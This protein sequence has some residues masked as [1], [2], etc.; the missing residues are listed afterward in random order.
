M[1][2]FTASPTKARSAFTLIEL[3][4][5]IAIIAILAAILFPV[6]ARARENARR[7]SCQSNLKQIGLGVMQYTQDYDERFPQTVQ[8]VSQG[9]GW[10]Q[11]I[12]PYIKSYQL[13]QCPSEPTTGAVWNGGSQAYYPGWV[14]PSGPTSNDQT[15]Y[16]YS[17]F[18]GATHGGGVGGYGNGA[19]ITQVNNP[20]VSI[21]SGD[22]GI[23]ADNNGLQGFA[24][25]PRFIAA[26]EQ[27]DLCSGILG[28]ASVTSGNCSN[29]AALDRTGAAIRHLEG[30]N[31]LFAD[32][33]VKF[34]KPSQLYGALTP[35]STSGGSPTFRLYDY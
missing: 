4:V 35:Y 1:K 27:G 13:F 12:N 33:H 26:G 31:Y 20:S 8:N 6:F 2:N 9:L 15:D 34:Q 18:A 25:M 16:F 28:A 11:L 19:T 30:A 29:R 10:V 7:S 14:P 21:L 32:G 24:D 17:K 5:V 3:L 22:Q 23:N